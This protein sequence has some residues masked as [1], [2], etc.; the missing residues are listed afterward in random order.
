MARVTQKETQ[1]RKTTETDRP[2]TITYR[3]LTDLKLDPKNPRLHEKKQIWQIA[4][5]IDAFGFIVPVLIDAQGNLL[6]GHGRVL[7]AQ[8]LG[9]AQVP[10]I[11]IE[12]LTEPQIRAFMIA[13]NHLTENA[14]WDQ[15]L[16][17]EQLKT[18]SEL[19][20][21]F[22]VEVT[23]FEMGEI[24]VMVEGLA[25]AHDAQ[26]DPD[27]AL[28]ELPEDLQVSRS[29]DLW[30]LDRHRIVCGNALDASSYQTLLKGTRAAMVFADPPYNVPIAGHA[31]GLGK[32][33]HR[34]FKMASGEMSREEFTEF[35]AQVLTHLA[36][37]SAD[38]SLHFVC[39]DWRHMGEL[40]A[41][42][43]QVYSELKN[44]CVWVKDNGG[45]GSLYRSQHELVFVFKNGKGLHR[46]NVQL[47]QYGRYRAN[48]WHYS[49]VNSF[50]RNTDEGNLLELHPTVKPVALV[51]D[52]ILDCTAR[53]DVVLDP[54]LGS[55]TTIIA[56][57]RTG[58][59]SFGIEIDPLYVDTAI[60]RWQT[61]TGQEAVNANSGKTFNQLEREV[62]NG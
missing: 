34:D 16:L 2:L 28:P 3:S 54:F 9:M 61:F 20:L 5:S 47:G 44:L 4:H 33:Q 60:R 36:E 39:M 18:L 58:R 57:E 55:G 29:G 7:A 21:N 46:N 32:I 22:S 52:A 56:A 40:L 45:M 1:Q 13:D 38:G 6:A 48:V 25:P 35:L 53:K 23:G 59:V 49:G 24:D 43:R 19:D 30:T 27:N 15:Q 12:H 11:M 37:H 62:Q 14:E 42:G 8:S 17:A 41:A 10:T 31:T 26:E 50:S 51:A